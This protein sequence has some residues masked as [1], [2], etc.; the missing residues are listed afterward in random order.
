[1]DMYA[2][3]CKAHLK[4]V[5]EKYIN[6]LGMDVV[7]KRKCS[8]AIKDYKGEIL[9]EFFFGNES[10]FYIDGAFLW[11]TLVQVQTS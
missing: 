8:A 9:D 3:T 6:H 4:K 2:F 11:T 10:L 7:G 1:M 5:N